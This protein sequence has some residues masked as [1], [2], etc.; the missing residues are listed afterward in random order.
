M[1]KKGPRSLHQMIS[2]ECERTLK[3]QMSRNSK[4]DK[5]FL[6]GL[7][8]NFGAFSEISKINLDIVTAS[9]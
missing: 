3:A 4:T 7:A 2:R 1:G 6:D 9:V 5:T 8:A